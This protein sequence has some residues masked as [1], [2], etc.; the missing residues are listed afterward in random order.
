[1]KEYE[2]LSGSFVLPKESRVTVILTIILTINIPPIKSI[3]LLN[4]MQKQH[5]LY[6]AVASLNF[7][8]IVFYFYYS[9]TFIMES[10][11]VGAST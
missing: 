8:V 7:F 4:S 11:G 2:K 5:V 6:P 1:M 9:S 3:P 10:S